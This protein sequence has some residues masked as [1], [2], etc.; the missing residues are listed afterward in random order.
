MEP[1]ATQED[2]TTRLARI[3]L[4]VLDVDGTLTDGGVRYV[5]TEEAMCF[6]VLDGQGLVW[7]QRELGIKVAWI[8]GRGC[9]ATERRAAE[10]GIHALVQRPSSKREALEALQ[11]ELGL[12]PEQTLAMGDDLPDLGLAARAGVFCA[13]PSADEEVRRRADLVT[14]AQAGQGAVR[15]VAEALLRARG[16]W[17]VLV[18]RASR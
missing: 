9:S 6:S 2:W 17:D 4:V 11:V 1:Q 18:E 7:L 15:E 3:Q 13:P 10:L 16:A 8:T 14:E 12:E 5:G